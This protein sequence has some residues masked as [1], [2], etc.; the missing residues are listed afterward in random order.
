M[1][2]P[3]ISFKVPQDTPADDDLE[4]DVAAHDLTSAPGKEREREPLFGGDIANISQDGADGMDVDGAN[5]G[6]YKQPRTAVHA[7]RNPRG[8]WMPS[9]WMRYP[10]VVDDLPRPPPYALRCLTRARRVYCVLY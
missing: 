6:A 5:G 8:G 4:G 1:S 2:T 7:W 9:I 3:K 10:P